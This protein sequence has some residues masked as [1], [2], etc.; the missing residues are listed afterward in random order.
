MIF[1]SCFSVE[2]G[3]TS[4]LSNK[5]CRGGGYYTYGDDLSKYVCFINEDIWIFASGW[6]EEFGFK[7]VFNLR[8][9]MY[10]LQSF[11]WSLYCAGIVDFRAQL[12]VY[13]LK[14][15]HLN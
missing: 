14:I 8:D 10:F 9:H 1:A 3:T 6:A 5:F 4:A 7:N 2:Q 15:L 11:L 13:P 12:I